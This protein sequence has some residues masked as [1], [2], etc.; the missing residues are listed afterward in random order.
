[1]TRHLSTRE[2]SLSPHS[3]TPSR[4]ETFPESA[5]PPAMCPPVRRTVV[6]SSS[7]RNGLRADSGNLSGRPG[8]YPSPAA[9]IFP[10]RIG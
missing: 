9:R 8:D 3:D 6:R 1:M 2:P 7:I 4:V 10:F 5:S